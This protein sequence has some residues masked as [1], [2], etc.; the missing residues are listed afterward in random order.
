MMQQNIP[1]FTWDSYDAMGLPLVLQGVSENSF[2]MLLQ[3]LLCA[4]R[5]EKVYT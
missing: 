1:S 5:Y 4:E 2:T 3:M